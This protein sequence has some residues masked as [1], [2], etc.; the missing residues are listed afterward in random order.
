MEWGRRNCVADAPCLG[1]DDNSKAA[2]FVNH[3]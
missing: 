1:C 3:T 2:I